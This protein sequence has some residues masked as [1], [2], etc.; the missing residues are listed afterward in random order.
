MRMVGPGQPEWSHACTGCMKLYKNMEGGIGAF[1]LYSQMYLVSHALLSLEALCSTITDGIMLG[2][3]C[4]ASHDCKI[5]LPSNQHIFCN[6]HQTLYKICAVND[7]LNSVEKGF[8][9]CL[10]PSHHAAEVEYH[11]RLQGGK[12]MFQLKHHLERLKIFQLEDA[13]PIEEDGVAASEGQ[14][15]ATDLVQAVILGGAELEEIEV[16]CDQKMEG[17]N[18][19]LKAWFG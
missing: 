1:Y 3:P 15:S 17:M 2:H 16:K 9:T 7:C 11:K 13:I 5:P 19:K 8:R 4:C 18:H 10:D 12:A 14:T 6:E